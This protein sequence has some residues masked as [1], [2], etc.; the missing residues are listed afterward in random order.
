MKF[1]LF[2]FFLSLSGELLAPILFPQIRILGFMPIILFALSRLSLPKTVWVAFIA[3]LTVDV[4]AKTTPLGFFA[5]NYILSALFLSRYK[6]FFSE[7]KTVSFMFYASF[8]SFVSTLLHFFLY[9][10]L[11]S[12]IKLTLISLFTD[13]I[14]MPL[15]DGIY[16]LIWAI[17]P[18]FLY[19]YLTDPKQIQFY[20]TKLGLFRNGLSR[21]VSK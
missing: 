20:K 1:Y 7:E 12:P 6:K 21:I 14:C 16:T 11:G 5:L 2:L 3:G 18:T 19:K 9:P 4:Y 15:L 8:F 10:F 13:L 17:L